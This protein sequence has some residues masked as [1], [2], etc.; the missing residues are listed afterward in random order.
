MAESAWNFS[1]YSASC[2]CRSPPA[3][4]TSSEAARARSSAAP[5]RAQVAS[6]CWPSCS[7]SSRSSCPARASSSSRSLSSSSARRA[8][9]VS[10]AEHCLSVC[11][12]TWSSATARRDDEESSSRSRPLLGLGDGQGPASSRQTLRTASCTIFSSLPCV[13]SCLRASSISPAEARRRKL[14]SA[15][16]RPRTSA[17]CLRLSRSSARAERSARFW[18][19]S[20]LMRPLK[21]YLGAAGRARSRCSLAS[22]S[23]RVLSTRGTRATGPSARAESGTGPSPRAESGPGVLIRSSSA[24]PVTRPQEDWRGTRDFLL[25]KPK[26]S[27]SWSLGPA[28]GRMFS[29]FPRSI[30]ILAVPLSLWLGQLG[31]SGWA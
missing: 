30:I 17:S 12:C 8:R 7:R 1:A 27:R 4:R 23:P 14:M 26:R 28:S 22:G 16:V 6:R 19:V 13:S 20:S 10:V 18:S 25:V 29:S 5:S 31:A 21:S 2:C 11:S 15:S 9:L 3:S 24:R